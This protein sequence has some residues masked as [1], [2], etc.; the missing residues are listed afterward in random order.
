MSTDSISNERPCTTT[1]ATIDTYLSI[2]TREKDSGVRVYT[3]D[4]GRLNI[5]IGTNIYL[6]LSV[7][8]WR[9]LNATVEQHIAGGAS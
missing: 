8:D 7:D 3:G 4:E 1:P 6:S 2:T 9:A 5:H